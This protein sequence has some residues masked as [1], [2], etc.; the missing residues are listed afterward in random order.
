VAISGP[1]SIFYAEIRTSQNSRLIKEV[2]YFDHGTPMVWDDLEIFSE[3]GGPETRHGRILPAR[4]LAD[5][6][7]KYMRG[8]EAYVSRVVSEK[9]MAIS[10]AA[11]IERFLDQHVIHYNDV[12][13]AARSHMEVIVDIDHKLCEGGYWGPPHPI[14]IVTDNSL[15]VVMRACELLARRMVKAG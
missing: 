11:A 2:I 13:L 8:I 10:V 7:N 6:Y 5:L 9:E 4:E 3:I 15:N 14:P 12:V 1:G